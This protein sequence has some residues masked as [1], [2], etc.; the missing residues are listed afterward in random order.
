MN[1]VRRFIPQYNGLLEPLLKMTFYFK[2]PEDSSRFRPYL[3]G[4]EFKILSDLTKLF[5]EENNM[6]FLN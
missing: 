2:W 3:W 6:F 4:Q 1:Y 5:Q